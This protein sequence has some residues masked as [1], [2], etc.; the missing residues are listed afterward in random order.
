LEPWMEIVGEIHDIT[1]DSQFLYLTVDYKVLAFRKGGK[2]VLH[3]Q[4]QLGDLV[5]KSV[6][7]IK[8]DNPDKPILIRLVSS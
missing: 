5:G 3:I 6:A 1:T 4:N 7:I 2:D 8:T